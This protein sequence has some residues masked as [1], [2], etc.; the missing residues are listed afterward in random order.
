MARNISLQ[1]M[2]DETKKHIG[3]TFNV[4]NS[5]DYKHGKIQTITLLKVED[6][7]EGFHNG[8]VEYE[9]HFPD[10]YKAN[11]CTLLD[12]FYYCYIQ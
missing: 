12:A 5:L 9:A 2:A 4:K 1:V 10:G 11:Y 7:I 3:E 8:G 6:P